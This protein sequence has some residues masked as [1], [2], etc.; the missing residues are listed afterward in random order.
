MK[1]LNQ[2][3]S[4]NIVINE[5]RNRFHHIQHPSSGEEAIE[6][7]SGEDSDSA[8]SSSENFKD[9]GTKSNDGDSNENSLSHSHSNSPG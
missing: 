7:E 1:P 8:G 2:A 5:G 9:N 6:E 3:Q 4:K